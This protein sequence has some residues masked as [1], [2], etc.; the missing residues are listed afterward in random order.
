MI[1]QAGEAPTLCACASVCR[2]RYGCA[3]RGGS[4]LCVCCP[5]LFNESDWGIRRTPVH[6]HAQGDPTKGISK[7]CLLMPLPYSF[8]AF[9]Y[10]GPEQMDLWRL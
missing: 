3:N 5:C 2:L 4:T 7:P 1:A 10:Q 9:S 6:S 8:E